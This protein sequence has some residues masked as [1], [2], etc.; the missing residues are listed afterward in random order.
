MKRKTQYQDDVLLNPILLYLR[1][2]TTCP[3]THTI[4][5]FPKYKN[6]LNRNTDLETFNAKHTCL[7]QLYMHK[8]PYNKTVIK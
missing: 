5:K 1:Q 6:I 2:V 8:E 7:K 4:T 3:F